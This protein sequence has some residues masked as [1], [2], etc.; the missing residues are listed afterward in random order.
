MKED[1]LVDIV[2]ASVNISSA[3]PP[4][5]KCFNSAR[6]G[7]IYLPRAFDAFGHS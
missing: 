6:A 2:N 7:S 5:L 3:P 1:V 4:H